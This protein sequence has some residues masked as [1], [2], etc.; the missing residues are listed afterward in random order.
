[1]KITGV[2]TR[3][4]VLELSRPLGDANTP[5]GFDTSAGLAVFVESDEGVTGVAPGRQER[6][7][8]SRRSRP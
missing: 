1:M 4:Y 6:R 2:R 7:A 3:P 8:R 5:H